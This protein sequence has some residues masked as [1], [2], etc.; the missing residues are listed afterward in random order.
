MSTIYYH[1]II[2]RV[3]HRNKVFY[4][5]STGTRRLGNR[6]VINGKVRTLSK[7]EQSAGSSPFSVAAAS[8]Q[9]SPNITSKNTC[10][11]A[12]HMATQLA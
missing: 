11:K 1:L 7:Q 3:K 8:A 10:S 4:K 9:T 5:Y 12:L 2:S 6:R